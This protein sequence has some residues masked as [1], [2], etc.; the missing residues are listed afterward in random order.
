MSCTNDVIKTTSCFGVLNDVKFGVLI[1]TCIMRKYTKRLTY[2][3][4]QTNN[5][6]IYTK[7]SKWLYVNNSTGSKRF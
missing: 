1:T 6:D 3:L 2:K 7:M 4:H 5:N